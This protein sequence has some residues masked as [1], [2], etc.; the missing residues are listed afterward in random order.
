MLNKLSIIILFTIL[1]VSCKTEIDAYYTADTEETVNTDVLTLLKQ[2]PD[3][4]KFVALLEKYKVDSILESGKIYTFFVPNDSVLSSMQ[5]GMLSEKEFVEYSM[6]ESFV[7]LNQIIDKKKI[8]TFGGKFIEIQNYGAKGFTYDGVAIVKG[9]PL[10]NN[11]RFYEI[12]TNVQP[13]P[14]LL[15]YISAT[16][17]FYS[18]FIHSLDSVYLDKTLSTPIGY[19]PQGLT[20]Y[21]S[22]TTKINL[23][24][25]RYFPVSQEFKDRKATMLLFSQAQ[26]DQAI[27]KISTDLG[28]ATDRVPKYWQNNVLMPY[29]IKQT[30]FRN[31]LPFTS[32]M[33][34]KAKNILGDSVVVVPTNISPNFIECSNGRV[35][36]LIDFKVPEELYKVNS[37]VPMTNLIYTKGTNLW[38]WNSDV[39][40]TGQA[41]NPVRQAN[42]FAN[43]GATLMLDMGKSFTGSFSLAYKHKNI[44]PATYKFTLRAN[45]SKTGVYNIYVNNKKYLVDIKDGKG[46]R[47]D[48]DFYDLRSGVISPVTNKFFPFK[49]NF[50]SFELFI[51]NII[52]YGDIEVKLVYVNP[53]PRNLNNCGLNIDFISLEFFKK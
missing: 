14:S 21:D 26:Y 30:V 24:E 4:S 39:L 34:G 38:G 28:I 19:T 42:T 23:F 47:S 31:A 37:I 43:S 2:N 51:D 35:Y 11:G 33:I 13:K 16:N 50:C 48:F 10:A 41:F 5:L 8:Q 52:E 36:N 45:L 3:Y 49:D 17:E 44:F 6:T 20:I 12:A 40:L 29:L 27:S 32:F 25:M 22:V 15:E 53:S 7:N 1:L 18:S 46:P 9:S